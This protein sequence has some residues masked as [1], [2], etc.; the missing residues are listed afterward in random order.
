MFLLHT[1]VY[2]Y[3]YCKVFLRILKLHA[4]IKFPME[5][6]Y[7]HLHGDDVGREDGPRSAFLRTSTLFARIRKLNAVGHSSLSETWRAYRRAIIP[8]REDTI[9]HGFISIFEN[10]HFL[11]LDNRESR[12]EIVTLSLSTAS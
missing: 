5:Q 1:C 4:S 8:L 7:S 2:I 3:I 9:R 6:P 10:T 11:R 12:G